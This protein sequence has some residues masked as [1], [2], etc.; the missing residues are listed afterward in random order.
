MAIGGCLFNDG[1]ILWP[2]FP[3]SCEDNVKRKKWSGHL[4]YFRYILGWKAEEAGGVLYSFLPILNFWLWVSVTCILILRVQILYQIFLRQYK[5]SP[6]L[7]VRTFS[8]W[9]SPFVEKI[10]LDSENFLGCLLPLFGFDIWLL[11]S[12]S[13]QTQ[14]VWCI[15]PRYLDVFTF[16]SL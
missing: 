13:D 4:D 5:S 7:L 14:K 15:C 2:P 10:I 12:Q 1:V 8:L 6:K 11:V 3:Q 9:N 16:T